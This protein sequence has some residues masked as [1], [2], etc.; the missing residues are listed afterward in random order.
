MNSYFLIV[1]LHV[2][3]VILGLGPVTVLVIATSGSPPTPFPYDHIAR[4]M[5]VTAWSLLTVFVTG[6]A[7]IAM[8]HGA[9][10]EGLWMRLSFGLFLFLGFLHG[11]GRR[12]LR[13]AQSLVPPAQ[14]SGSLRWIFRIMS[15][16]IVT[17]TWLMEAK[18]WW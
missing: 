18:P 7:A 9:M 8:T 13:R 15:V 17:I 6:A 16:V 4:L 11:I 10:G 12:L 1:T 5:R 3:V 14:P 2:A